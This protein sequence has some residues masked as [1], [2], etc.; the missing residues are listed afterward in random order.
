MTR[1]IDRPVKYSPISANGIPRIVENLNYNL[2]P[3]PVNQKILTMNGNSRKNDTSKI[4]Q[5]NIYVWESVTFISD[6]LSAVL[7]IIYWLFLLNIVS[8]YK[9]TN[10]FSIFSC[11][12]VVNFLE[13][14][15]FISRIIFQCYS[16]ILIFFF[17]FLIFQLPNFVCVYRIRYRLKFEFLT[18]TSF[19]NETALAAISRKIIV[20]N[21]TTK[22][23]ESDG[24]AIR[25]NAEAENG[26]KTAAGT[27]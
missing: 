25:E 15:T 10:V 1:N 7:I 2:N 12:P 14:T 22:H 4:K 19:L 6:I 17:F 9:I 20:R 23:E 16:K 13:K 3:N 11:S 8:F 18:A 5:S 26:V 27:V 24:D 21:P